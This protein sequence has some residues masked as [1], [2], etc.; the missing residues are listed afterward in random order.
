[1]SNHGDLAS[2]SASG[3]GGAI[4]L[5][6]AVGTPATDD[7]AVPPSASGVYYLVRGV[8]VCADGPWGAASNGAPRAVSAC[9]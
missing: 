8:N 3:T 5:D 6:C 1:M 4:A 7:L 2:L 9:P